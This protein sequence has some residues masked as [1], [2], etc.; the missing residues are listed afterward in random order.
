MTYKLAL[1][2]NEKKPEIVNTNGKSSEKRPPKKLEDKNKSNKDLHNI[3]KN[4]GIKDNGSVISYEKIK[5]VI[6]YDRYGDERNKPIS[7]KE[8]LA[9]LKI[10]KT[11]KRV[12]SLI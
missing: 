1:E 4:D 3:Y 6:H 9:K 2:G 11:K 5:E 10:V 7:I 8:A 12:L